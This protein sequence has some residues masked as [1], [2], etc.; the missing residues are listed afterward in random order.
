[1]TNGAALDLS[2]PDQILL[3]HD[4]SGSHYLGSFIRALPGHRMV[5][6]ICNEDAIDPIST[7]LSFFGYRHQRSADVADYSLRRRRPVITALLDEYFAFMLARSE[8]KSVVV[9]VKV[10]ARAQYL[11]RRLSGP[12]SAR[13]FLFDYAQSR[14]LRMIHLSRWNSLETVISGQLAESRKMWHA[15]AEKPAASESDAIDADC[16]RVLEQILELNPAEGRLFEVVAKRRKV[17][18]IAI[19]EEL[20]D[21]STGAGCWQRADCE[22]PDAEAPEGFKSPYAKVTPALPRIVRNWDELS[23]FCRANGLTQY[24]VPRRA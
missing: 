20:T 17:S 10:R 21:P 13:P 1:M 12:S 19:C 6:E 22:I 3:S 16:P 23:N 4:R 8:G 2:R 24:L 18:D 5:D 14:R 9:D 15:I 11:R 7:P